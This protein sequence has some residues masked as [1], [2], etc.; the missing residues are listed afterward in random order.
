MNN[1]I[2]IVIKVRIIV[3]V[4]IEMKGRIVILVIISEC[5]GCRV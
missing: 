3:I 2:K 1:S 4:I 5:L